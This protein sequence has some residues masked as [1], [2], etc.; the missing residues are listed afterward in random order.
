MKNQVIICGPAAGAAVR[1]GLCKVFIE[2]DEHFHETENLVSG[3]ILAR[4]IA[5][6]ACKTRVIFRADEV[7]GVFEDADPVIAL[8][9]IEDLL[10]TLPR[11]TRL[12]IR[13]PGDSMECPAA[14]LEYQKLSKAL[15][16][17]IR[18]TVAYGKPAMSKVGGRPFIGYRIVNGTMVIDPRKAGSIKTVFEV[19]DG[20]LLGKDMVLAAR[21]KMRERSQPLLTERAIYRI[22]NLTSLYRDGNYVNPLGDSITSPDLVIAPYPSAPVAQ[23]ASHVQ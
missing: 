7:T 13:M 16:E 20:G 2:G 4:S 14:V 12:V 11:T 9:A 22:L 17:K 23:E 3:L 19:R 18:A 10:H 21:A 5:R 1:D 6:E 15:V 8:A